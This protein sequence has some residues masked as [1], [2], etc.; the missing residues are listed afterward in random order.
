MYCKKCG[1]LNDD[2]SMFCKH[3]GF[4]I[5]E[6]DLDYEDLKEL[7]KKQEENEKKDSKDKNN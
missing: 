6:Q 3:C 1:A 2:D 7:Q 5:S 4:P